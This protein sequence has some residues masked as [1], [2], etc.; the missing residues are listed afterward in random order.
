[1]YKHDSYVGQTSQFNLN[2]KYILLY[3]FGPF[4]ENI[5]YPLVEGLAVL[6]ELFRGPLVVRDRRLAPGQSAARNLTITNYSMYVCMYVY[7]IIKMRQNQD[8]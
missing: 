4:Q 5:Y 3:L 2:C 8:I 1:M 6:P 7:E